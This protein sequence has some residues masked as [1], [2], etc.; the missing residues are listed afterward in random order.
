MVHG[1]QITPAGP[2]REFTGNPVSAEKKP[3]LIVTLRNLFYSTPAAFTGDSG[4]VM[5]NY[6]KYHR[7]HR[8]E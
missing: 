8:G 6:M 7:E 2:G 4:K 5:D 3:G 1:K